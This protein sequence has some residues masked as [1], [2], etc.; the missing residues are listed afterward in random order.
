[1]AD[2][3]AG[4]VRSG[5]KDTEI[6]RLLDAAGSRFSRI[7]LGKHRRQHLTAPFERQRI[8][9]AKQMKAQQKTV[10]GPP[11]GD[12]LDLI[13][14]TVHE[15]VR[16][17]EQHPT[18]DHAIRAYVQKEAQIAKGADRDFLL[19]FA[20][21]ISGSLVPVIEG[22]FREIDAEASEDEAQMTNLLT[23]GA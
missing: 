22:E 6:E 18:I 19:L 10:K 7:T 23:A 1:M 2:T 16:S 11:K 21:A 14:E 13:I 3:I 12:F 15:D 8:E 20:R 9:A 17:G 5:K 4:W